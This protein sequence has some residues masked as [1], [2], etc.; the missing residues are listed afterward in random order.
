[1]GREP[2]C[3]AVYHGCA[4]MAGGSGEGRGRRL[5]TRSGVLRPRGLGWPSGRAHLHRPPRERARR[6]RHEVGL[7]VVRAALEDRPRVAVADGV[8]ARDG[9]PRLPAVVDGQRDVDA[10]RAARLDIRDGHAS[11]IVERLP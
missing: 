11:L 7:A 1:M 4:C 8:R 5:R 2:Y 10:H 9:E 3:E 6:A